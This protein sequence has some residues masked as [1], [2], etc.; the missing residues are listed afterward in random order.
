MKSASAPSGAESCAGSAIWR[1][2]AHSALQRARG[3]NPH[4]FDANLMLEHVR[5]EYFPLARCNVL[6]PN[7]ECFCRQ[8]PPRCRNRCGV[9]Q[10]AVHADDLLRLSAVVAFTGFTSEDRQTGQCRANGH[11]STRR[12]Q[13]H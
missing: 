1:V 4:V 12:T 11:S 5:T 7:P 13:W 2:R 8:T 6:L 9:R 3:R 10:D